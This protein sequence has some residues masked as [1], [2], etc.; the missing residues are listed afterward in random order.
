[1]HDL[2]VAEMIQQLQKK[3]ISSVE[4]T[5]HYLQ[6]INTLD[7]QLNSYV[8]TTEKHALTAAKAA[9][10]AIASGNHNLLTGVPIAH[11]DLFCTQGIRTTACSKM[12]ESFIPPYESTVTQ[13]CHD[14][15]TVMLGKT[16]MDEFAMGSSNE[17]SYFGPVKNPWDLERIPGGSSGGSAACVA[18]GLAPIATGTDTGGSIRQ[19]AAL[20]GI[21]GIR[22]T[23]GRVS[24]Y[25][26]IAFASSL[27][28]AGCFGRSAQ[29]CA[30]LLQAMAGFDPKDATCVNHPVDDYIGALAQ[31][32]KG[33]KI[34]LPKEYFN[35]DLPK[36]IAQPIQECINTLQQLGAK[37]IEISLPQTKLATA[38]YYILAPAEASANLSRYDGVRYGYR[39]DNPVDL[40]DLYTR[41]R[42]EGFG[43]EVKR[44]I[45]I[46][47]Y[48]LSSG[49]YD[50]YY[51]KAQK[52]RRL[53]RD[54]FKQAFAQ[55][56]LMLTPTTPTTAFKFGEKHD[57]ENMYL[58]DI[59]TIAVNLAGACG[60]S[61]PVGFSNNLPVGAQLIGPAFAE[62]SILNVAHQFQ[63]NSDWHKQHPAFG[64]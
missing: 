46:G 51:T 28:Q 25:G 27:D 61:M 43:E 38:T 26:Q 29:D 49:Y 20:C 39:C 19:P 12:L 6:R 31:S 32:I 63:L 11:K 4:L 42:S 9:D 37:L 1:M 64:A 55:V 2:S 41:S 34:G 24:R 57:P 17:N 10:Q 52:L 40:N 47:T 16:N 8:T 13:R 48:V 36:T 14:A 45:L 56:D 5:Q 21:T 54:D 60:L 15:G 7:Q 62:A 23:Y 18:A 30:Y 58:S 33:K 22:P 35:Q 50:A 53:F 59:Y 44:R 3:T